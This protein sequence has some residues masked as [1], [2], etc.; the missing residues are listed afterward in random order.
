MENVAP[1]QAQKPL[2]SQYLHPAQPV[3]QHPVQ[4]PVPQKTQQIAQQ[5]VNQQAREHREA[6]GPW[7]MSPEKRK[8]FHLFN[9]DYQTQLSDSVRKN[10]PKRQTRK[11]PINVSSQGVFSPEAEPAS[12]PSS[13]PAPP[14]TPKSQVGPNAPRPPQAIGG[15]GGATGVMRQIM[16]ERDTRLINASFAQ[17]FEFGIERGIQLVHAIILNTALK[18]GLETPVGAVLELKKEDVEGDALR[19]SLKQKSR[20][21]VQAWINSVHS[22]MGALSETTWCNKEIILPQLA[23]V[24]AHNQDLFDQNTVTQLKAAFSAAAAASS[25]ASGVGANTTPSRNDKAPMAM[26]GDGNRSVSRGPDP[27]DKAPMTIGGD[28]GR[29]IARVPDANDIQGQMEQAMGGS[30]QAAARVARTET[31]TRPQGYSQPEHQAGPDHDAL[32]T[33]PVRPMSM[34]AGAPNGGASH[35][36]VDLSV[37]TAIAQMQSSSPPTP[38]H[39]TPDGRAHVDEETLR[40]QAAVPVGTKRVASHASDVSDTSI[41]SPSKRRKAANGGVVAIPSDTAE[42]QSFDELAATLRA[43]IAGSSASAATSEGVA[44]YAEAISSSPETI[45]CEPVVTGQEHLTDGILNP[46]E[47]DA[48]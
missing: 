31:P 18:T 28:G 42:G 3:I 43:D 35:R 5:K 26:G 25:G 30:R 12:L 41:E 33:T 17:G 32:V 4:N 27:N 38:F 2:Y 24:V 39:I 15:K 37:N 13:T 46:A 19:K 44:T 20:T 23:K 1:Q 6:P 11:P 21:L 16:A 34:N 7:K 45:S 10:P 9:V 40:S 29:S 36:G 22:Q 48:T 47:N 8:D 14:S